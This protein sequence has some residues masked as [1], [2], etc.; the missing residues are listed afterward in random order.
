MYDDYKFVTK[1]ELDDLG[2][3]HL[4]GQCH[5]LSISCHKLLEL[6]L[7]LIGFGY[8]V[9]TNLLRAYMHGYFMDIRLYKKAKSVA[10]PFEFEQYRKKKI[11]EKIEEERTNRVVLQV[12]Q[13]PITFFV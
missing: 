11:K 10:D 6:V 13:L 9:G 7:Y 12:I 2:L 3:D 8:F 1:R 5:Y 4:I